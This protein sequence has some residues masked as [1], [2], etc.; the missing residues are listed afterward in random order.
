[1]SNASSL[2]KWLE[3]YKFKETDWFNLTL[4]HLLWKV[5][6]MS[7]SR[8]CINRNSPKSTF[9]IPQRW[10]TGIDKLNSGPEHS[11]PFFQGCRNFNW[12]SPS[13]F[14]LT[15]IMLNLYFFLLENF[16]V[17]ALGVAIV[18]L[19]NVKSVFLSV[20]KFFWFLL[21]VSLSQ[22]S[23]LRWQNVSDSYPWPW[24]Q[25]RER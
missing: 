14:F 20:W 5:K 9:F 18:Y 16:L 6:T 25:T 7:Y 23:K 11:E 19:H 4:T 13:W 1:M 3:S 22:S 10:C 2:E 12:N 24:W 21:L 8:V 15:H 17:C